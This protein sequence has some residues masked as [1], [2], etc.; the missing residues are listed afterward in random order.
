MLM[1]DASLQILGIVLAVTASTDW[2]QV[3]RHR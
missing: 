3:W 2:S 1:W